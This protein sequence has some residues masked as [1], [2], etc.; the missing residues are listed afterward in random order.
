MKRLLVLLPLILLIA[1]LDGRAQTSTI[2]GRSGGFP[3]SVTI[4]LDRV[5]LSQGLYLKSLDLIGNSLSIKGE[6]ELGGEEEPDGLIVAGTTGYLASNR[7]IHVL[8]LTNPDKP[9]VR[10]TLELAGTRSINGLALAGTVL[11]VSQ[12]EDGVRLIDVSN[13]AAPVLRGTFNANARDVTAAG[14]RAYVLSGA[15]LDVSNSSTDL[16]VL[17]I[18]DPSAPAEMGR[19]KVP[20][21]GEIVLG[22]N[23]AFTLGRGT[24]RGLRSVNV[25][26][27]A[28]MSILDSA[29]LGASTGTF[30]S[31]ANGAAVQGNRLY[32]SVGRD[33]KVYDIT[34]PANLAQAGVLSFDKGRVTAVDAAGSRGAVI[35]DDRV[36]LLNLPAAGAP[37]IA[38]MVNEPSLIHDI[39]VDGGRQFVVDNKGIFCYEISGAST[40]PELKGF[41]PSKTLEGFN[42]VAAKGSL[43]VALN[44]A[45]DTLSVV[46]FTNPA[47]PVLRSAIK[48]ANPLS[49]GE[50]GVRG[51]VAYVASPGGDGLTIVDI[52]NPAAPAIRGTH[53]PATAGFRA[54]AL[55]VPPTG[56]LVVLQTG[57][58]G[59]EPKEL[60]I[61]DVS[62]PGAPVRRA[63]IGE[64]EVHGFTVAEDRLYY[65]YDSQRPKLKI[66]D[67]LNP[68]NP[69]MVRE[70]ELNTPPIWEMAVID[71]TIIAS[72]PGG[73]IHFFNNVGI[74]LPGAVVPIP[75]SSEMSVADLG[76]GN[77]LITASS[78]FSNREGGYS[79]G[80]NGKY[81][82]L[83]HLRGFDE[84]P[85]VAVNLDATDR[86]VEFSGAISE[87]GTEVTFVQIAANLGGG[88]I[89]DTLTF[90]A[91][92]SGDEVSHV[93][94]ARLYKGDSLVSTARFRLDNGP[95]AF[96]IGRSIP[97]GQHEEFRINY[98]FADSLDCPIRDRSGNV[99]PSPPTFTLAL[100]LNGIKASP[101][102]SLHGSEITSASTKSGTLTFSC[103]KNESSGK[104]FNDIAIAI[105]DSA[106]ENGQTISVAPGRYSGPLLIDKP[107]RLVAK[108][109]PRKAFV[110]PMRVP[111]D[112]LTDNTAFVVCT[113][114]ATIGRFA[115]GSESGDPSGTGVKVAPHSNNGE[116]IGSVAIEGNTFQG[117]TTGL[118]ISRTDRP[119]VRGNVFRNCV[120]GAELAETLIGIFTGNLF[121]ENVNGVRIVNVKGQIGVNRF[122]FN[123]GFA[124]D[125]ALDTN[126]MTYRDKDGNVVARAG[127]DGSIIIANEFLGNGKSAGNGMERKN[128]A[129]I[130]GA[131]D[132]NGIIVRG[133]GGSVIGNRFQGDSVD[134]VFLDNGSDP[135]FRKNLF[136]S[137]HGFGL[138]N[139]DPSVTVDGRRNWWGHASGPGGAGPGT[140]DEVSTNVDFSDWLV[141]EV[142]LVATA[143]SDTIFVPAGADESFHIFLQNWKVRDDRVDVTLDDDLGWL[144]NA[145]TTRIEL[146]DSLGGELRVD[147]TVPGVPDG[148]TN[149]V[150]FTA[151]S[152][153]NGPERETDSVVL[154]SYTSAMFALG[155]AP[156]DTVHLEPGDS[157]Q[158]ALSGIDRHGRPV[159][160]G[161][162]QWDADG[163]TIDVHG[164]Y[165]AGVT[166]GLFEV[167]GRANGFTAPGYVRIGDIPTSVRAT[168]V[169][170]EAAG[171]RLLGVSP[172]PFTSSTR[173]RF[174]LERRAEVAL[175]LHNALGE[176]V[177]GIAKRA[178]EAGEHEAELSAG[179]LESGVYYVRLRSAGMTSVAK[180]VVW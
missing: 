172:N 155:I 154:V 131:G 96:P 26:N 47:V 80:S 115:I 167:R 55:H 178:F 112:P 143:G 108:D 125:A 177:G 75:L 44:S 92:G 101:A 73:S 58:I 25:T 180:V 72:I 129:S 19:L 48:V 11:A 95:I 51:S 16:V 135:F 106:L 105:A 174:A 70:F 136:L 45:C 141:E 36:V 76:D 86:V 20:H 116:F 14:T 29:E 164:L 62:N 137:S 39:A 2:I 146:V 157:V 91:G 79:Y 53:R 30:Q 90:S 24:G 84:V 22:G 93:K 28:A 50:V 171:L 59:S 152:T 127:D 71:S 150:R 85:A 65:G 57:T 13:P 10:G 6:L 4:G 173:I 35:A 46:D 120:T 175:S 43:A 41:F 17:N 97:A 18:A 159:D 114:G 102:D 160:I 130:A 77:A 117:L 69:T 63:T 153:A 144:K 31:A 104:L 165:V 15:A 27:P 124:I 56:S 99:L 138:H 37:T 145:A 78:G 103:V 168:A 107:I 142:G 23:T 139:G 123:S 87:D 110:N 162:V 54:R 64:S 100:N 163:G 66:M 169:A 156:G 33:L 176:E 128:D 151:T 158:F 9:V 140:G 94:E 12:Q 166:D 42:A 121:A 38:G 68:S 134:A 34:N 122:I 98:L 179:S 8:D 118:D 111:G 126:D 170:G 49:G 40:P 3:L 61:V 82:V 133:T 52:S 148:T 81:D 113:G 109:G 161:T 74:N 147:V 132:P 149:V 89:V 119:V 7:T 1:S 83:S 32:A 60:E 5:F 21:A 67:I 88:W